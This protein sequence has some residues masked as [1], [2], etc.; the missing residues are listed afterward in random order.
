MTTAPRRRR[1]RRHRRSFFL[2]AA[3]RRKGNLAHNTQIL[4]VDH[5]KRLIDPPPPPSFSL[6]GLPPHPH[7]A[8]Y[9]WRVTSLSSLFHPLPTH[10]TSPYNNLYH[11]PPKQASACPQHSQTLPRRPLSRCCKDDLKTWL[12]IQWR[13]LRQRR[14]LGRIHSFSL[15]L[16]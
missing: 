1:G 12:K 6:A 15:S 8:Q 5:F 11:H 3:P 13:R 16:P 14:H 2:S 9:S 10:V 4:R 7:P